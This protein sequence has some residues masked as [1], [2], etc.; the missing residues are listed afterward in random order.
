MSL[1][2]QRRLHASGD[3]PEGDLNGKAKTKYPSKVEAKGYAEVWA[4]NEGKAKEP[5]TKPMPKRVVLKPR[6]NVQAPWLVRYCREARNVGLQKQ[7]LKQAKRSRGRRDSKPNEKKI[8]AEFEKKG[9][10]VCEVRA[11]EAVDVGPPGGP[12]QGCDGSHGDGQP[13]PVRGRDPVVEESDNGA[14]AAI[15]LRGRWW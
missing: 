13:H 12:S 9:G 6:T 15:V 2:R 10:E 7:A 8:F 4:T 3:D 11:T 1:R 14:S 5:K